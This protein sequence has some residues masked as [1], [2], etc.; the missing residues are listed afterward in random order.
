[1]NRMQKLHLTHITLREANAF[2][3]KHHRHHPAERGARFVVGVQTIDDYL[4]SELVGVAIMGRPKS[5]MLQQF[6][7]WVIEVTRLCTDGTRNACSM[8]YGACARGAEALGYLRVITYILESESGV[9]LKAS[10]WQCD[11]LTGGGSWNRKSR[12]RT[13][14]APIVKKFRWSKTV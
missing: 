6:E 13:D 9:S 4:N 5:R 12:P 8:L 7:P 11:G 10:G 14:K 3:K 2:I 1:M